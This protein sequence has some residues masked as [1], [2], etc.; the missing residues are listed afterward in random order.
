MLKVRIDQAK[1][2]EFQRMLKDIPK[3]MPK[4]MSRGINRTATQARTQIARS[5]SK[6]IGVK[7]GDVR[8]RV[9]IDPKANYSRWRSVVRI[10]GRRLSLR[11]LKPKQTKKGMKIKHGRER[12]LIRHAFP[13]LKGWFIRLPA[14]GGYKTNIGVEHALEVSGKQLV[15]R[16]PIARIK[17]PSLAQAFT[18]AQDEANR[19]YTESLQK[20]EKNI[21]DQVI[22]ILKKK[23][24]A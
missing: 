3:A 17:G 11:Y 19:I 8:K 4:V 13:A 14:A 1:I 16:M 12:I 7:V 10:S 6:R 15:K 20:L 24:P 9:A 21:N 23:I 18:A 22:L 5:L 2:N